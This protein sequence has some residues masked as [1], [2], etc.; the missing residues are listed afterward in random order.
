MSEFIEFTVQSAERFSALRRVFAELKFDKDADVW[1]SNEDL[2][3]C[4]DEASL[5]YFYWPTEEERRRRLEDLRTRIVRVTP[6]EK[7]TSRRWD[8]DSL[9]HAF[10]NGE[11]NLLSCDLLND[12]SARLSFVCISLSI[13]RRGLHGSAGGVIWG[14]RDWDRRWNWFC[15]FSAAK[16]MTISI[17]KYLDQRKIWPLSG[18]HILAN[19][20][21]KTIIAIRHI[22]LPLGT[23]RFA[24]ETSAVN[25]ATGA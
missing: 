9:V 24:T 19:F 23:M 2:M 4:F 8:F 11:Y 25:S 22:H 3:K 18:K 12:T 13:W 1:R 10:V 15:E 5:K 7:T 6:T 17:E 14:D 20:D 21:E 16:G